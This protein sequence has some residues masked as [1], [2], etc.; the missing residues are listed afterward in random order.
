MCLIKACPCKRSNQS[1]SKRWALGCQLCPGL[2]PQ[3]LSLCSQQSQE[4]GDL[5]MSTGVSG[6]GSPKHVFVL[7]LGTEAHHLTWK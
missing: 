6:G 4:S 1:I 3:D 2:G 7:T 5:P